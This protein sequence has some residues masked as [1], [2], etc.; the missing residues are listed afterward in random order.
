[1]NFSTYHPVGGV[2]G[3][4]GKSLL[5]LAAKLRDTDGL[6]DFIV[7]ASV[8]CVRERLEHQFDNSVD[9]DGAPWAQPKDD[10]A[11]GLALIR[12]GNLRESFLDGIYSGGKGGFYAATS[13]W[14]F[15]VR[16]D[17]PYAAI[18]HFGGTLHNGG[19]I[20]A[21]QIIP[22][23]WPGGWEPY[24]VTAQFNAIR[25]WWGDTNPLRG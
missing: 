14:Y 15:G 21:H 1:M 20:P 25:A 23:Q 8:Q 6:M 4:S 16:S 5:D 24:L 18:Q 9:P 11:S 7:D 13:K 10:K 17:S 12:E 2:K 19:V 22:Y 3:T